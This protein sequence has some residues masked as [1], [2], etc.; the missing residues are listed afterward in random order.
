MQRRGQVILRPSTSKSDGPQ[1]M[2][3]AKTNKASNI[4]RI[5]ARSKEPEV[6]VLRRGWAQNEE[7]REHLELL[8]FTKRLILGVSS[9]MGSVWQKYWCKSWLQSRKNWC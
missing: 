1:D 8:I 5:Q 6:A 4:P 7:V 2:T 9:W 3:S